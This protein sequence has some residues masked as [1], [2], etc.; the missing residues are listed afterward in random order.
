MVLC[1]EEEEEEEEHSVECAHWY[2]EW[3]AAA[4]TVRPFQPFQKAGHSAREPAQS[5]AVRRHTLNQ[6]RHPWLQST[7]LEDFPIEIPGVG[8]R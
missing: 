8:G 5:P 7:K 2:R 6:N 1:E 4:A 3:A